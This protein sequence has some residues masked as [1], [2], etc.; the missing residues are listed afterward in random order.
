M[1]SASSRPIDRATI[2][3]ARSC[4]TYR[5]GIVP[6]VTR[7]NGHYDVSARYVLFGGALDGFQ[8]ALLLQIDNQ[9][10]A[11]LFVGSG[12]EASRADC[13]I[14]VQND[15]QLTIGPDACPD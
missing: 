15:T 4:P 8:I 13:L 2:F 12:R 7:I 14:K 1:R 9:P 6:S 11:V 5:A 10:I 3:L